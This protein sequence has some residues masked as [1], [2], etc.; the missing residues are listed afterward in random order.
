MKQ[1]KSAVFLMIVAAVLLASVLPVQAIGFVAEEVYESVFVVLSYDAL[2]S[3]F[4]IGSNCVITN[5]HVIQDP[6]DVLLRCYDGTE[7]KAQVVGMDEDQDIA[8]LAVAEAEFI[9]LPVAD[10]AAMY[11]GSDV[12]AIGAP[13]SMAYTLTKGVLSA[14]ERQI[15]GYTYI[16]T[17]A[18][19]NK[20]NSGGPLL[21]DAGEVMGVNTLKMNDSEGIGLAIPIAAVCAYVES[22]G[23]G[24][25]ENGNVS[26]RIDT[27]IPDSAVPVLPDLPT[28][29]TEPPADTTPRPTTPAEEP[30]DNSRVYLVAAI[31][32]V[33][34]GISLLANVVLAI[35]L[36]WEKRKKIPQPIDPRER[37]DFE[38]DIWE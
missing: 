3:G 30:E 19:I 24:L 22:L 11:T 16:Q 13:K 37:T 2:G 36:I 10:V 18:P 27:N 21:N 17:D 4:A 9:P 33:T 34:A 15:G 20:G 23:I 7:Y 29:E 35:L 6:E 38:I 14:K 12:Y 25:D 31:G 28:S 26:G 32:C 8:V 1:Y 5:A